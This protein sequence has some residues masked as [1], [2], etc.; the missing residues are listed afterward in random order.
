MG[1]F[2]ELKRRHVIKVAIVYVITAVAVGEAAAVFF[3]ALRLPP[4]TV[5]FVMSLLILGFPIALVVAWAFEITPDGVRPTPPN[6]MEEPEVTELTEVT[7][8]PRDA[9]APPDRSIAV[10]PFEN[11]SR[12][13]ENEFFSDG[14]TEAILILLS[15]IRDL[16]VISRT[17][18]MAYKRSSARIREIAGELEVGNVV[19]GSV[20]R[21]GERV[22]IT[23]QLV[24]ART[25]RQLWGERYDR[26]L[27]DVFAIQNEV[28]ERIVEA[29]HA[30]LT[31]AEREQLE[32]RPTEDMEAYACFLKGRHF[33]A[34][35]TGSNTREAVERFREA[36]RLDPEFA[37]AWSGLADAL[38]LLTY[39]REA[40]VE[41]ALAEARQAAERALELDPDLG[42]AHA[43]VG[44]VA[45][46]EWRWAEAEAA[47]RRAIDLA[48]SYADAHHRYG[49]LLTYRGRH[50]ES[51]GRFRRALELDPLSLPVHIGLA[52]AS[53]R[54]GRTDEALEVYGEAVR[55]DPAYPNAIMGIAWVHELEGR[56]GEALSALQSASRHDPG[57]FPPEAVTEMR[58][59]WEERGESGYW[60]AKCRALAE[61]ADS[62]GRDLDRAAA[63]VAI[64]REEEALEV[65]E[66][67]VE[68]REALAVMI[69]ANPFFEPLRSHPRFQALQVRIG[70][71]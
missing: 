32:R 29:L 5:T 3:P 47:F 25:D 30:K 34:R 48:P 11:L 40:P 7:E 56:C 20:Q 68:R 38:T 51:I 17:S 12:D 39:F 70:L 58:A 52:Y 24:D 1:F 50:E 23:A 18:V 42:E 41:E 43:S 28:A 69:P 21:V 19:E 62:Y 45:M 64:G 35:R 65:L 27:E 14:L 54:A 16:R 26:D 37:L 10:L 46:T 9:P 53:L 33:L 49:N 44:L 59:A 4:W 6:E 63:C 13:P 36:V 57:W 60:E 55:M 66:R 22:R 8:E 31:P 61:S 67:M 71:G 15:K 2:S